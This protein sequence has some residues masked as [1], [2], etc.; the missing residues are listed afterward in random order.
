MEADDIPCLLDSHTPASIIELFGGAEDAT[1]ELVNLVKSTPHSNIKKLRQVFLALSNYDMEAVYTLSRSPNRFYRYSATYLVLS[2]IKA[3]CKKK[4][5]FDQIEGMYDSVFTVRFRD[6][7][8]LIRGMSVQF[9]SEWVCEDRILRKMTYLKYIGWA[10]NDR[11]DSVRKRAIRAIMRLVRVSKRGSEHAADGRV[12]SELEQFF[13]RYKSRLIEIAGSDTNLG[14]QKDACNLIFCIFSDIRIFEEPEILKVL[15]FDETVTPNKQRAVGLMLPDGVWN[16]ERIHEVFQKSSGK[17]FRNL[18]VG[19]T[20][21]EAFISNICSFI[22][23]NSVCCERGTLCLLDVLREL[24]LPVD[25]IH[26]L[27]LFEVTKDNKR[28]SQ[29]TIEC[30]T[31]IASYTEYPESTTTVLNVLT[32]ACVADLSHIRDGDPLL[33][34]SFVPLLKRLEDDFGVLVS[35]TLDTFRALDA[36]Y[37]P[38]IT[39]PL[40]KG[41]DVTD[42]LAPGSRSVE[43]CYGALWLAAKGEYSRIQETEFHDAEFLTSLVDFLVLFH[44]YGHIEVD[45]VENRSNVETACLDEPA[46]VTDGSSAM[47]HLYSKLHRVISKNLTFDDEESCLYLFKMIDIGVFPDS[48]HLLYRKCGAETLAHLI[49]ITKAVKA[50]VVGFFKAVGADRRL[51]G[52]AKQLAARVNKNDPDRFVFGLVRES[53]CAKHLLD[54]VSVYFI[55]ALTLNECIVLENSAPKSRFKTALSRACKARAGSRAA[56]KGAAV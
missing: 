17:I 48:A 8:P 26:L 1:V 23:D 15:L 38:V 28:N 18:E 27:P 50:M 4:T 22:R 52:L 34:E 49:S 24:D 35:E 29:K 44:N 55:P 2:K 9:L 37:R 31:S 14:L 11:C 56:R 45:D 33:L 6:V 40:V 25:P 19:G 51:Y 20:D 36:S 47:R 43:K 54:S 41:F 13:L 16:L 10:L 7:D 46:P 30:F 32:S 53:I 3:L 42:I 39:L 5:G 21:A 12:E